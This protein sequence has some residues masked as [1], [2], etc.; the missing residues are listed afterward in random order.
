MLLTNAVVEHRVL[1]AAIAA[2]RAEGRA[3]DDEVLADISPVHAENVDFF[4]VIDMDAEGPAK[5][6]GEGL[7]PPRVA[8]PGS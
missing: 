6:D 8:M 1:Q 5:L 7:R 3:V 2:M 4:G